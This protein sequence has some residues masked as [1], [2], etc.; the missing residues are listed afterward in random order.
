MEIQSKKVKTNDAF[1]I[2][3]E[4]AIQIS[5]VKKLKE[6]QETK[7]LINKTTKVI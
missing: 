6:E 5:L 3:K 1:Q 2:L 4:G 7:I